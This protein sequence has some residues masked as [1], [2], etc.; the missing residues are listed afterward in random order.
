MRSL[1]RELPREP[2]TAHG[3]ATRLARLPSPNSEKEADDVTDVRNEFPVNAERKFSVLLSGVFLG[4]GY[5]TLP[6]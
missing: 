5:H 4:R 3:I 6:S 1:C 2:N